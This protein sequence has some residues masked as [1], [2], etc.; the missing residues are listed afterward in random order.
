[1]SQI[2]FLFF[3]KLMKVKLKGEVQD[4]S[5]TDLKTATQ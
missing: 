4:L 5:Q 2:F 3:I 1:M